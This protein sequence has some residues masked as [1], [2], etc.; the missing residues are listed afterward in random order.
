MKVRRL[1]TRLINYT[2]VDYHWTLLRFTGLRDWII[3]SQIYW[4]RTNRIGWNFFCMF[5]CYGMEPF[6]FGWQTRC[7]YF[8]SYTYD[9][10]TRTLQILTCIKPKL[11]KKWFNIF[12]HLT[13]HQ[14]ILA[15]SPRPNSVKVLLQLRDQDTHFFFKILPCYY[16]LRRNKVK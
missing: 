12:L 13:L 6:V 3:P 10:Q 2:V 9:Q 1:T 15:L 4:A 8:A 14:R 7:Q 11:K 16:S 5:W